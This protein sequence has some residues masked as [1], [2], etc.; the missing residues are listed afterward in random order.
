M[1]LQLIANS[2]RIIGGIIA[3]LNLMGLIFF[4]F[5]NKV[6]FSK[7][8]TNDLAHLSVDIKKVIKKQDC[9]DRKFNTLSL[10]VSYLR[11]VV[12]TK[13]RVP[14]KSSRKK[15]IRKIRVTAKTSTITRSAARKAAKSIE[16]NYK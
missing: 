15:P 10:D 13:T 2:S 11:G 12:D 14:N 4:Y 3:V 6:A 7:I 8:M 9:F 16:D 5:S 1:D